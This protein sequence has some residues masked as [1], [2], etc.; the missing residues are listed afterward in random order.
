MA[1]V[2]VVFVY[3]VLD[4]MFVEGLGGGDKV[5]GPACVE[6]SGE[7][8]DISGSYTVVRVVLDEGG[9]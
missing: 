1:E 7:A 3:I 8:F 2:S 9:A 4:D 5:A 6:G